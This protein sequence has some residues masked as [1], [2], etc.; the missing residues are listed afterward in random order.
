M[1]TKPSRCH[2]CNEEMDPAPPFYWRCR[3][4]IRRPLTKEQ[5]SKY[6]SIVGNYGRIHAVSGIIAM[7]NN[8]GL[9]GQNV[10]TIYGQSTFNNEL[11]PWRVIGQVC[12]NKE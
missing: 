10:V 12:E 8:F 6:K 11:G 9:M 1:L 4:C 3:H 2:H 5:L 7:S